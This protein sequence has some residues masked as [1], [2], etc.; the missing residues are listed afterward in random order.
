MKISSSKLQNPGKIQA[1]ISDR[2]EMRACILDFGAWCFSGV[3]SL[4]LGAF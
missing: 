1:P 3:W 2:D 4:E